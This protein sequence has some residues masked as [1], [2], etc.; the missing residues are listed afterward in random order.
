[1]PIDDQGY[2]EQ[3][4]WERLFRLDELVWE[5]T[6]SPYDFLTGNTRGRGNLREDLVRQHL[7]NGYNLLT[8]QMFN[9]GKS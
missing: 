4:N 7:V 3:R 9:F 2:E 1:M 5:T 8:A 6:A